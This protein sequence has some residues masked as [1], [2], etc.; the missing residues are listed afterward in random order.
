[1]YVI[2]SLSAFHALYIM[3]YLMLLSTFTSTSSETQGVIFTFLSV[4]Y[5]VLVTQQ[6]QV[7]LF[8]G[9][10]QPLR[11]VPFLFCR[12]KVKSNQRQCSKLI[13]ILFLYKKIHIHHHFTYFRIRKCWLIRQERLYLEMQNIWHNLSCYHVWSVWINLC[14]T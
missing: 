8:G 5:I 14:V 13:I 6:D 2:L 10:S 7:S 3:L 4:Y 11:K 9:L 12:T 1:M